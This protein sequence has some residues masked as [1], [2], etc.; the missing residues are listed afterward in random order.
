MSPVQSI[1][2]LKD[3]LT[4]QSSIS[5]AD[6]PIFYSD[7]PF[8]IR[9]DKEKRMELSETKTLWIKRDSKWISKLK[10][11]GIVY[12]PFEDKIYSE[13]RKGANLVISSSLRDELLNMI[14]IEL[15]T[16]SKR[17]ELIKGGYLKRWRYS[18]P[19]I[20]LFNSK[21]AGLT[22]SRL[23]IGTWSD[24]FIVQDFRLIGRENSWLYRENLRG[25]ELT[26][27]NYSSKAIRTLSNF[28]S[29]K[30]RKSNVRWIN[31]RVTS[32]E[33][34]MLERFGL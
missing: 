16:D 11:L 1:L 14:H 15:L 28:F 9:G 27:R 6:D 20:K 5:Y 22:I 8:E 34:Y 30:K 13:T 23:Y 25:T 2:N 7:V 18:K 4:Q 32:S 10:W 17:I 33:S 24:D 3:L 21:Y 31:S 26:I 19:W 29:P 12:D